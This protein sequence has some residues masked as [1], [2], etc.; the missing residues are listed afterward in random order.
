MKTKKTFA[1]TLIFPVV[2]ILL[3]NDR[4]QTFLIAVLT[5]LVGLWVVTATLGSGYWQGYAADFLA[6]MG[7][8]NRPLPG[9]DW[10]AWV[11]SPVPL[12]GALLILALIAVVAQPRPPTF[13]RGSLWRALVVKGSLLVIRQVTGAGGSN[14]FHGA[15][16]SARSPRAGPDYPVIIGAEATLEPI[17]VTQDLS[18]FQIVR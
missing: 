4:T 15:E 2:F 16:L 7:S 8:D 11:L 3:R 10:Q 12:P 18:L 1:V 14:A 5:A 6:V 9:A 17:G 13:G